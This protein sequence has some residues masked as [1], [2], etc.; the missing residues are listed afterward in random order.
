MYVYMD[1]CMLYYVQAP[2]IRWTQEGSISSTDVSLTLAH[3][4]APPLEWAVVPLLI[5]WTRFTAALSR[6]VFVRARVFGV[7]SVVFF[8]RCYEQTFLFWRIFSFTSASRPNVSS[9]SEKANLI[10]KEP[11]LDKGAGKRAQTWRKKRVSLLQSNHGS[12]WYAGKLKGGLGG[13]FEP[14]NIRVASF[15]CSSWNCIDCALT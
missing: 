7:C 2:K 11:K 15:C 5:G 10:F 14:T 4:V 3:Y 8:P 12:S 13:G 1:V 9:G 6:D